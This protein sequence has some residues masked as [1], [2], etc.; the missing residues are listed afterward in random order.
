M[1]SSTLSSVRSSPL[2]SAGVRIL[3]CRNVGIY[4]G[5]PMDVSHSSTDQSVDEH[6][7]SG[8]EGPTEGVEMAEKETS[9][10]LA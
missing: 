8:D 6:A 9:E 7:G 4:C 1:S 5:R 2:I 3:F 10:K